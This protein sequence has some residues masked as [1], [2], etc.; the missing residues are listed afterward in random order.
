M[1]NR[2]QKHIDREIESVHAIR[3][4]ATFR[5]RERMQTVKPEELAQ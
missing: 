2:F 4:L 1:L 5:A 3:K